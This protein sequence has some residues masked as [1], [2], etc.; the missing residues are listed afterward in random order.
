MKSLGGTMILHR[1]LEYDYCAKEALRSLV[2]VCDEV[3]LMFS[4]VTSKSEFEG[5]FEFIPKSELRKIT[6]HYEPWKPCMDGYWLADLTNQARRKLDTDFHLNL[7]ADEVL[8]PDDYPAIRAACVGE[9]RTMFNRLNFW[10]N[11]RQ[12]VDH[13]KVCGY[14]VLRLAPTYVP[15]VGDAESLCPGTSTLVQSPMRIY[16]YGFIRKPIPQANK[17]IAMQEGWIKTH[18]PCLDRLKTE[19]L[20]AFEG[21]QDIAG[22][23][24]R[25]EHPPIMKNWLLE[26]GFN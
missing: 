5:V 7:Q 18:D 17:T 24:F 2:D 13:G 22:V 26:R 16:H 4:S 8:H 14:R 6:Y 9:Q 23:P 10:I 15:S 21:H 12:T 1:A 3:V 11:H 25:G 19:G 20:K